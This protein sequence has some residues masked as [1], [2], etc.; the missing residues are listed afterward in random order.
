MAFIFSLIPKF[1][2][3]LSSIWVLVLQ[4]SDFPILYIYIVPILYVTK[5][6]KKEYY[7]KLTQTLYSRLYK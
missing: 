1:L 6:K 5:K 3:L 2:L 4:A 7:S